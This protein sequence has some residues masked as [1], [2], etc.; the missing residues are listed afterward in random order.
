MLEIPIPPNVT[1][2]PERG[3]V[4]VTDQRG[5]RIADETIRAIR[6]E[7]VPRVSLRIEDDD[8]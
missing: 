7:G 3:S 8:A 5:A 1:Y 6:R 4:R 2:D